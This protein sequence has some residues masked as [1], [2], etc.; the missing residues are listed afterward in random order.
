M[1][2]HASKIY[3]KK[4]FF[5]ED[6]D[7]LYVR[8]IV[9]FILYQYFKHKILRQSGTRIY[10]VM[11]RTSILKRFSHYFKAIFGRLTHNP[12]H[13]LPLHCPPQPAVMP[14]NYN[15]LQRYARGDDQ[16]QEVSPAA[17]LQFH[18]LVSY[19]QY[20]RMLLTAMQLRGIS[21]ELDRAAGS[22]MIWQYGAAVALNYVC[23]LHGGDEG[24]ARLVV[25]ARCVLHLYVRVRY[26]TDDVHASTRSRRRAVRLGRLSV[27]SL[28]VV[29]AYAS[30]RAR[31]DV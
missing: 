23:V 26:S 6:G 14:F 9:M 19:V 30:A 31:G 12:L 13:P 1:L 22:V 18:D 5:V 25:A 15:T 28:E 10:R 17:D 4:P 3:R 16:E 8:R 24:A 2:I 29:L 27:S 21:L 11:R 7:F 20:T